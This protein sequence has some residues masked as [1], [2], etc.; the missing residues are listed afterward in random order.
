MSNLQSRG[1]RDAFLWDTTR[2]M[3]RP[4]WTVIASFQLP[5]A[6]LQAHRCPKSLRH[7]KLLRAR[8]LSGRSSPE[9][10][11]WSISA[12]PTYDRRHCEFGYLR[13]LKAGWYAMTSRKY[14]F[15]RGA[16]WPAE[17][18]PYLWFWQELEDRSGIPW[19]GNSYVMAIDLQ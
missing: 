8:W 13:N 15:R 11:G 5:G 17:V 3:A 10:L 18:F 4:S 6:T 12:K 7:L 19:Y 9:S 2:R 14:D 16:V 1:R